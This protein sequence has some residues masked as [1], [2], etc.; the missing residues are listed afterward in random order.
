MLELKEAMEAGKE[1]V[2]VENLCRNLFNEWLLDLNFQEK[3]IWLW[4]SLVEMA[5]VK[6]RRSLA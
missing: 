1:V 4:N 6:Q 2:E 3:E 5:K